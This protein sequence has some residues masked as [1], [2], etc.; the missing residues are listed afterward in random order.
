MCER[1]GRGGNKRKREKER[2][3]ET[4]E[5]VETE[6]C[7]YV[8]DKR[9]GTAGRENQEMTYLFFP[10]DSKEFETELVLRLIAISAQVRMIKMAERDERAESFVSSP[11]FR[12]PES[13]PPPWFESN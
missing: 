9:Q 3:K 2:K 4:E 10:G 13:C 12:P 8:E 1:E 7:R 11:A 5:R 6:R